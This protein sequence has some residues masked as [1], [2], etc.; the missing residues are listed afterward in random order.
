[1]GP[2]ATSPPTGPG[3]TNTISLAKGNREKN[4]DFFRKI[5]SNLQVAEKSLP[6]EF[7]ITVETL[8]RIQFRTHNSTRASAQNFVKLDLAERG[9]FEP[10]IRLLTV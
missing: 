8:G 7:K 5:G 6:V 3:F 9:G 4:R 10:P 1:M 2:P